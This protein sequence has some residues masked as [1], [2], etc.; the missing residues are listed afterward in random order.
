MLDIL[1]YIVLGVIALGGVILT[2][3][4][5]PGV[6]LVYIS[7]VLLSWFTG[8]TVITPGILIVLFVVSVVSTLVDNLG[9][10]LGAKKMG[11]STWGM[12][13]A[14][15][16]GVIGL[17]VGNFVGFLIGPIVGATLFEVVFERKDLKD[18]FKAGIGSFL[19]ILI[20]IILRLSIVIGMVVYVISLFV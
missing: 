15:L 9:L 4:N 13:G 17:F 10:L 18:A 8:F 7:V 2:V 12:V 6:W 14:V 19:G 5:L 11:A 16:G 20:S 1:V 3:F